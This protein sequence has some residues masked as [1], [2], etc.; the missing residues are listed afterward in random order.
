MLAGKEKLQNL[1]AIIDRNNIQ[2]DGFT[3]DIMPLEPLAD[4]WRAWNW[5]V[6]EVDGHNFRDID[7]AFGEARAQFSKPTVIIANTIPSK[8][9]PEF[10]RM[11]EWHGKPPTTPE[12]IAI[13][14]TA[15]GIQK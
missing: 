8:G 3:E 5:H 15:L 7:R 12:E 9:I 1:T 2:I 10:E 6:I 14:R 4:K 13:A 11:F